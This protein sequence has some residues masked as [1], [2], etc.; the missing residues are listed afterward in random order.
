MVPDE[1]IDE[2]EAVALDGAP[3][4]PSA[5]VAH[6]ASDDSRKTQRGS[7]V[8]PQARG[9][10]DS[11]SNPGGAAPGFNGSGSSAVRGIEPVTL[12]S[13]RS[14]APAGTA[15]KLEASDASVRG[16]VPRVPL[17]AD[18][19]TDSQPSSLASSDL[20]AAGASAEFATADGPNTDEWR[21]T[22]ANR[23]LELV[24]TYRALIEQGHSGKGA[25]ELMRADHVSLWRY[26]KAFEKN[27]YNGLIPATDKCGRKSTI[28][29]LRELL[30]AEEVEQLLLKIKG[31]N[32]DTE[33]TTSALRIFAH[34]EECP[35]ELARI[36]LDPNRCS[37]HALP[38]SLRAHVKVNKNVRDAH[39]G[40]RRLALKGIST[41]RRNDILGGDIFSSDDTTPIWGWWVPWIESEDYPFGVKLMQGQYLPMFDVGSQTIITAALIARESSSYRASDIWSLFGYTFDNVGVPRLG[42][43]LERGSWESNVIRGEDVEYQEDEVTLNRRVGGLRQLPTNLTPWHRE[44]LGDAATCFPPT[45]QTWTSYLPKTKSIEAAFNR[46]QTLEGTLWGCLGRDQ[47]RKPFERTKKIYEAC[48]RGKED[49][50]NYFLSQEEMLKRLKSLLEY[51]NNEPMEGE[52]FHGIPVQRFQQNITEFPLYRLPEEQRWLYARDWKRVTITQGWARVRLTDEITS[53]RFSLFYIN[54][55]VFAQ[56]EGAEVFVYYDRQNFEQPAQIVAAKPVIVNGQRYAP[57]DYLCAAM[58]QERVG[59]FLDGDMSGH[60]IRKAWRN[61]VTTAYAT[62]V[63]FVPSRQLPPEIQ[64]R[65]DDARQMQREG[66]APAAPIEVRTTKP[67]P[68]PARKPILPEPSPSE[69]ERQQRQL[70]RQAERANRLRQL[71]TN[72]EV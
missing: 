71:T 55:A 35:E 20:D 14:D 18:A 1:S 67:A 49:P 25:A 37:K 36:I 29:K 41:P 16:V 61:A 3:Q 7:Y 33:S 23:R 5:G 59:S 70:Q 64:Q 43:Q 52:V 47:M 22:E 57:G 56:I 45:L 68:A 60:E 39:R 13:P 31:I 21:I 53:K 65:R 34:S 54:P 24:Q 63:P 32:A 58:F 2:V 10:T 51:M 4:C 11:G 69:W 17:A 30:G 19:T 15:A 50:R 38:P 66:N 72:P 44:K 8:E 12:Q 28:D 40:P 46:M 27:G 26:N 48:R 9:V 42:F 6:V 62:I